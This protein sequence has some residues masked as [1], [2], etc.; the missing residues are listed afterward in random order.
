MISKNLNRE[1]EAMEVMSS[2]F[3]STDNSQEFMV[4]DIIV[5]FHWRKGLRKV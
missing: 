3:E 1:R 2:S 4:V 5:S